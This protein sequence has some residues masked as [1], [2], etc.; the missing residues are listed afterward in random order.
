MS[1]DMVLM[2]WCKIKAPVLFVSGFVVMFILY[3]P[4]HSLLDLFLKMND[5]P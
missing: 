3:T 1:L 4:S 5:H 2:K